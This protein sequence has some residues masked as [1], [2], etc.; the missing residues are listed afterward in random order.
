MADI[1][2]EEK[3]G[4]LESCQVKYCI[5]IIPCYFYYFFESFQTPLLCFFPPQKKQETKAPDKEAI[6]KATAN[7]PKRHTDR[8]VTQHNI[9]DVRTATFT[10]Q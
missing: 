2:A 5:F 10:D 4:S 7:L 3:V 9:R 6:L 1:S 8:T